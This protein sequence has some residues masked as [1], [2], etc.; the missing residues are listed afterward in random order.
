[1]ENF[2]LQVARKRVDLIRLIALMGALPLI[3]TSR[4][5]GADNPLLDFWLENT[6]YFLI[7]LGL[8]GRFWAYLHIGGRKSKALTITGPYALCRHPLYFS[9][10]L[11]VLG[12]GFLFENWILFL[13]ALSVFL[14]FHGAAIRKEEIKLSALFGESYDIYR[15]NTPKLFPTWKHLKKNRGPGTGVLIDSWLIR[16]QLLQSAGFLMFIPVADLVEL[17]HRTGIL[18]NFLNFT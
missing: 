13:I 2:F 16:N 6:G 5:L 17:F 18:P 9:S 15:R 11:L 8:G 7:I 10:F 12:I 1:M 14:L 3:L 4:P